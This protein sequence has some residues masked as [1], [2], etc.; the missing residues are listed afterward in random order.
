MTSQEE[1]AL[2]EYEPHNLRR[3]T[4]CILPETMPFI[5]FD[6]EGSLQLLPPLQAA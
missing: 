5:S 4:R 2:L 6:D 1:E 3:C